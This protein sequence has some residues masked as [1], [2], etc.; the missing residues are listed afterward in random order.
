MRRLSRDMQRR[1]KRIGGGK[2]PPGGCTTGAAMPRSGALPCLSEKSGMARVVDL[3]GL[4]W[5]Q[6]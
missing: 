6:E 2:R 5:R 4:V 3:V 1:S